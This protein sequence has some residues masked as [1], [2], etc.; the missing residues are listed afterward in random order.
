MKSYY[1][2]QENAAKAQ[3]KV[4]EKQQKLTSSART[5]QAVSNITAPTG[6]EGM[7]SHY[8]KLEKEAAG[9]EKKEKKRL[10]VLKKQKQT[11]LDSVFMQT[12]SKNLAVQETQEKIR[13]SVKNAKTTQELRKQLNLHKANLSVIKRQSFLMDR[14]KA[15]SK[16]MLGNMASIFAVAGTGAFITKT[17]QDFESVRNTM[18]AVSSSTEEAGDNM[19]F[20][21]EEAFR[22]GLGLK[23]SAKG[24]AK[25]AAARGD[26]SLADT[27]KAFTGISEMSTLLGLSAD[28]SSRAINALQQMMSKGVVS[29]EEL[30]LQMGEVLPNAIPLMAK[31]AKEA[32]LTLNG[33]VAEMMDLQK[34]GGLTSSK[35]LPHFARLMS[36]AA[37]ANGA[38]DEALESNRVQ[39]N[40]FVTS[41]QNAA[42]LVFKSGFSE[43]L[44]EIFKETANMIQ[45][46]EVLW[47]SLGRVLGN[48]FKGFA[49][50]IKHVVNPVL[51][52]F[53]SIFNGI[54]A[55]FDTFGA[56]TAL[57]FAPLIKLSPTI[58]TLIK[59]LGGL[60]KV[61]W[62]ITSAAVRMT[63]PFLVIIG[64]LEEVAEFF[65]PTKKKTLLRYNIND[66]KESLK[67]LKELE[68]NVKK[69]EIE[70][71]SVRT[72][73]FTPLQMGTFGA[74]GI[75]RPLVPPP[76]PVTVKVEV[77][78]KGDVNLDG[79]LIGKVVAESEPVISAMDARFQYGFGSNY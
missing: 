15:S 38:L 54:V 14:M 49:W 55:M 24:F 56:S 32:G 50:L 44:S 64:I 67:G 52:A 46:N 77:E 62:G 66:L 28:E 8:E 40:R 20:V 45:E 5:K 35:V 73:I 21:K 41:I 42:D 63:L 27:K 74:G 4:L 2:E 30:K 60:K 16:Q 65:S 78:T 19:A 18:L 75:G 48:F 1:K 9:L 6:A 7:R 22:L 61:L 26:M 71:T 53:G 3:Q 70:G 25:M 29:A 31:A 76:M 79:N 57:A 37:Q 58:M 43:G 68:D 13:Q 10:E 34:V 72:P 33:T 39:M 36:E 17:G 23:E 47:K 69:K 59:G 51:S 12:K 11:I